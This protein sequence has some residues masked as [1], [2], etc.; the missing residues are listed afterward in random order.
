MLGE[1]SSEQTLPGSSVGLGGS[2]GY[3][4]LDQA[5]PPGL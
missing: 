1:A 2:R 4:H 3:T 5:L